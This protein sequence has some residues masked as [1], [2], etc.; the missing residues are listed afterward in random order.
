[1]SLFLKQ[2]GGEEVVAIFGENLLPVEPSLSH[3]WGQAVNGPD[4]P[5]GA[6]GGGGGGLGS[7]VGHVAQKGKTA[8]LRAG[9]TQAKHQLF[10]NY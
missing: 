3:P 9:A 8:C 7:K 10:L 4:N 6:G 2:D 1:M 5:D